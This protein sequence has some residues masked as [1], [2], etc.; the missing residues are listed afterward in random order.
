MTLALRIIEDVPVLTLD[1]RTEVVFARLARQSFEDNGT[2]ILLDSRTIV[3]Q[4][5]YIPDEVGM[6]LGKTD[7]PNLT[8][9]EMHGIPICLDLNPS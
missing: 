2:V 9:G 8:W 4:Q 5:H 7:M 6:L 3:H 1:Q